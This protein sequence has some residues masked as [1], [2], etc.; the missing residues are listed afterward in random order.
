M[1]IFPKETIEVIAQS[2]GMSN[3]SSDVSSVLAPDVEYRLREIMQVI[4]LFSISNTN[5]LQTEIAFY[6]IF[7]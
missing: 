2:M 6:L 3:L 5:C 7:F 4:I 1:S